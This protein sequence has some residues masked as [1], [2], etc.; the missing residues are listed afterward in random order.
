MLSSN[1]DAWKINEKNWSRNLWN[2]FS[3]FFSV[4]FLFKVAFVFRRVCYSLTKTPEEIINDFFK[5]GYDLSNILPYTIVNIHI[6]SKILGYILRCRRWLDLKK[7]AKS[8]PWREDAKDSDL[9]SFGGDLSQNQKLFEIK[10]LK[11]IITAIRSGRRYVNLQI[12]IRW[13]TK[14]C[15]FVILLGYNQQFLKLA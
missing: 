4:F 12:F 9:A 2:V 14:F 13:Q 8:R 1:E 5:H 7:G 6:W 11:D 10:Y 15:P 3:V